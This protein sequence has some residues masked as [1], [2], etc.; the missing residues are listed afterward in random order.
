[1]ILR[2]EDREVVGK[3]VKKLRSK[4]LVPGSIYGPKRKSLSIQLAVSDF[5]KIFKEVGYSNLFEV[6]KDGKSKIKSTT[7]R[8]SDKPSYR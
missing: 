3:K 6:A 8:S 2:V 5:R 1:M 4:G 7:E